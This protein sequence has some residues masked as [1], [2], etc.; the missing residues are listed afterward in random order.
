M[1]ELEHVLRRLAAELEWPRTPDIAGRLELGRQRRLLRPLVVAVA[2]AALALAVA[3]AV[4]SARSALLRLFGLGGV[5]I[6]RVSTLPAAE[7]RPLAAGLGT[8]VTAAEAERALGA[9]FRP[10]VHGPL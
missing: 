4:P 8:P 6:E 2:L 10:D 3:F 7:Q 9:P 1:A 5:T